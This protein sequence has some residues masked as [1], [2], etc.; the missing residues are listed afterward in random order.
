MEEALPELAS[1]YLGEVVF[2]SAPHPDDAEAADQGMST[3]L[4]DAEV[5]EL[6]LVRDGMVVGEFKGG[7]VE[8]LSQ[9]LEELVASA[10]PREELE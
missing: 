10:P 3:W 7:G 8:D 4:D 6:Q 1:E 5:P 2:V 9:V